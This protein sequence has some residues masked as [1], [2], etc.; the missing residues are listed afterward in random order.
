MAL[1]HRAQLRGATPGGMKPDPPAGQ[2]GFYVVLASLHHVCPDGLGPPLFI[3]ECRHLR[4][5]HVRSRLAG[6]LLQMGEGN[7]GGDFLPPALLFD[8][9]HFCFP[10]E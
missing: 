4:G 2:R 1:L 8:V 7:F 9:N 3:E 6:K 5:I 10:T